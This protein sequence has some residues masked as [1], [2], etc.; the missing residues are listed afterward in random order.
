MQI[1]KSV[2]EN[3][4]LL[5]LGAGWTSTFLIPLLKREQI[6]YAATTRN[7][8]D[9]TIPFE[10]DPR[11]SDTG[12]FEILPLA[13]TVLI[14]FPLQGEGQAKHLVSMY[15]STHQKP[16][17]SKP[18]FIQ[19]GATSIWTAPKWQDES[20]PYE[21][22]HS[23]AIAEDELMACS[24]GAVLNLAGLYG[25]ARQPRD[26]IDRVVKS[27]SDLKGKGALHVIHGEDVARAVVALHRNFTPKKRWL[28]TDMHVYDWWDLAQDWAIQTLQRAESDIDQ[29]DIPIAKI[30]R[31]RELLNWVGELMVEEGVKALPRDTSSVGRA[32]DGRGFW[33]TMRI[34]PIQG[35][36]R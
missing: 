6:K 22:N 17:N 4:N 2:D 31:Q 10:F 1:L 16:D 30:E 23:R 28:L 26:W 19:L 32:L 3:V 36:I 35:R 14:T 21:R 18:H 25:N 20:S 29:G 13:E 11:S 5:I 15:E 12:P 9:G 33:K 7:G 8:R 27:K 34:W 24:E